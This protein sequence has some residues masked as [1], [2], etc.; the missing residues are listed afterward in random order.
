MND[1]V[2]Q[3]R[4]LI[5]LGLLI[6]PTSGSLL[7]QQCEAQARQKEIAK[8]RAKYLEEHGAEFIKARFPRAFHFC[9]PGL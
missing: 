5:S 2:K 4:E 8:A 7:A 3:K 6:G 1:F 9:W